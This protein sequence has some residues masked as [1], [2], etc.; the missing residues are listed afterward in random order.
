MEKYLEINRDGQ[1]IRCKLYFDKKTE[2][3]KVVLYIHGFAGH[4]DNAA[5]RKFA[6]RLLTR[7]KGIAVFCFDL[8]CHGNDVK[9]KLALADCLHYMELAV[10]YVRETFCTE[11][12]YCYATSFGG[13]L[14]LKYLAERGNPFRKAALRCPAVNMYESMTGTL[15]SEEQLETL[16]KGKEA[17]VGF[18]RKIRVGQAFLAELAESDLF[19]MDFL[20]VCEDILILH[21]T[22]DEIIPFAVSERFADE[23][24]IEFL[25]VEGAD[26][27]FQNPK[28][29]ETAI[30]AIIAFFGF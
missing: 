10:Q 21:G 8:P 13:F 24:I 2:I 15:M 22:K 7:Y 3:R 14:T 28:H 26:H 6:E 5:A 19:A 16:R 4:K 30:K 12:L 29:M 27:R 18:D 17:E 1:N 11:E 25:P 23:K 20:P 9:K